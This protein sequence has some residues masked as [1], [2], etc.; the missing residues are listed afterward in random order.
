MTEANSKPIFLVSSPRSGS[1]LLRLILDAHHNIAI[2]PPGYI[3]H[4]LYPYLY[5]YGDL[6]NEDNFRE[7]VEDFL[8]IPTVKQWPIDYAVDEVLE[9]VME[10][11][12]RGIYKYVH[13]KYMMA[14][15]KPRW[16][17]KSPRNGFWLDE[18]KTLFSDVKIVHLVRD[19]RDVA[20]DLAEAD[21][22][23]HSVTAARYAGMNAF[24][25]LRTR[26]NVW[27]QSHFLRFITSLFV[28]IPK[29]H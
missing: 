7:L 16:G 20:I 8:E 26:L 24:V 2:P 15:G 5:S 4:F 22:Q 9:N 14:Q 10:R 29:K 18:I 21:F 12:F 23:P 19:G 1:T 11:N 13:V 3:F 17:N 27:T 6:K 28:L 25:L